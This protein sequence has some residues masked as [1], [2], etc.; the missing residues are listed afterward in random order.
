M[1][2]LQEFF[3]NH[4]GDERVAIKLHNFHTNSSG[5]CRSSMGEVQ[6]QCL[7]EQHRSRLTMLRTARSA[8]PSCPHAKLTNYTKSL[9][10]HQGVPLV[11]A[12]PPPLTRPLGNSPSTS[13]GPSWCWSAHNLTKPHIWSGVTPLW[14]SH[15]V[16]SKHLN[17]KACIQPLPGRSG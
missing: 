6:L 17:T 8:A 15:T 2:H 13:A 12:G 14:P 16:H 9:V 1:L 11:L 3:C 7:Q 10:T 5:R 4:K